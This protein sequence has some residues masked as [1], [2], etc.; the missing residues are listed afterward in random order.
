MCYI[1]QTPSLGRA[2]GVTDELCDLTTMAME[3]FKENIERT[4]PDITFR[5]DFLD[6]TTPFISKCFVPPKCT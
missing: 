6:F 2:Y 4:L 1:R 3:Y 5:T